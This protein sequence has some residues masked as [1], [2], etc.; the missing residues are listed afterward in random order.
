M[1]TIYYLVT[2]SRSVKS[3]H[4]YPVDAANALVDLM[5]HELDEEDLDALRE[6]RD[7]PCIIF[8]AMHNYIEPIRFAG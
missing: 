4:S 6:W 1:T 3:I 2:T 5:G 8:T 7:E